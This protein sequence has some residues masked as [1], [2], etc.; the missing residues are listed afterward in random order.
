MA[1]EDGA[2]LGRLLG[3]FAQRGLSNPILPSL[4][5]LYQSVRKQ[6]AATTV[7]TADG[8]R[9]LYHMLDGPEQQ[10]RDRLYATH[11]W[12]DEDAVFPFTY[13]SMAYGHE[14]Y[15]FDPLEAADKAFERWSKGHK[16]GW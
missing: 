11:D 8:H 6:R 10:E 1:V 3:R 7:K 4:L 5:E 13:G 2:T 15:G 12:W 9:K 16:A 14:L